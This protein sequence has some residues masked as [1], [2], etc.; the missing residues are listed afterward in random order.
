[1]THRRK[2]SVPEPASNPGRARFPA[3][4]MDA[5]KRHHPNAS[6]LMQTGQILN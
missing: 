5:C 6:P 4:P 1:V 3:A 2:V